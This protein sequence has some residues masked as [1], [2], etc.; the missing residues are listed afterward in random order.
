VAVAVLPLL[1]QHVADVLVVAVGAPH[2]V[3]LEDLGDGGVD[4]VEVVLVVVL[5]R[6][7]GAR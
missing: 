6:S 4:G 1:H 5:A 2:D 3:A 7:A